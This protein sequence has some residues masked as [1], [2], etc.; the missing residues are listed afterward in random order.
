MSNASGQPAKRR[1]CAAKGEWRPGGKR[2]VILFDHETFKQIN[3]R[4]TVADTSFAEQVRL[5][6][7]W[8]L[9]A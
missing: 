1:K 7:E 4:A 3:D 6:V 2:I 8:G 9:E 5:L